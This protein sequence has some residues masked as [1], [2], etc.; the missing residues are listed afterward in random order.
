MLKK[1]ADVIVFSLVALISIFLLYIYEPESVAVAIDFAIDNIIELTMIFIFAC[2]LAGLIDVYVEKEM[3]IK[4]FNPERR[5]I[6]NY[7]I[8]TILGI[9]TP[10]PVYSIFPIVLVLKKKGART[11]FIISYLTGQTLMGP[12]RVPLEIWF[13]GWWFFIY[14]AFVTVIIGVLAGILSRP[15]VKWI[16][17]ELITKL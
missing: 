12:M 11:D 4:L 6:T 5:D 7:F 14:R 10:G 3:I 17:K 2:L 9:I 13:L 15:F 1:Y 16:D 8:A